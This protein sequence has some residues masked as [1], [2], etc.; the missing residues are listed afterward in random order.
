MLLRYIAQMCANVAAAYAGFSGELLPSVTA[1][2]FRYLASCDCNWFQKKKK[3]NH[4]ICIHIYV[5]I[6]ISTD[7]YILYV[8]VY[9]CVCTCI[10]TY[11]CL[12]MHIHAHM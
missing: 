2:H 12:Y 8:H 7:I 9:V 11:M 1:L 4:K 5:H 6:H 10:Y 3:I